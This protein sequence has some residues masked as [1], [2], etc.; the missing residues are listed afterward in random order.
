M[1][2]LLEGDRGCGK[3]SL[4]LETLKEELTKAGGFGTV[5]LFDEN[6]VVR[7]YAQ[8]RASE[9]HEVN[10]SYQG[11][12]PNVFLER[13]GERAVTHMSVLTDH[14]L[15]LLREPAAFYLLDEIGGAELLLPEW[16]EQLY[17]MFSS[18]TPCI[19]VWKSEDN[20]WKLRKKNAAFAESY[21]EMRDWILA[22][23]QIR[24][25]RVTPENREVLREEIQNWKKRW[26]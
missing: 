2:L 6:G 24:L 12:M 9:L 13:T 4:I 22:Q 10:H 25:L 1:H 18:E 26:L 14:T 19:G 3:S 15:P 17:H 16:K 23:P 8:V 20:C 21:Q 7:G 5:R 11:H